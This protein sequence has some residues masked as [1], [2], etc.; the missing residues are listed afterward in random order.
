M[1]C[2]INI[3]AYTI[4]E[5]NNY[6]LSIDKNVY[7]PILRE[8]KNG[9]FDIENECVYIFNLPIGYIYPR[10]YNCYFDADSSTFY[11][12]YLVKL[13]I[14]WN[15]TEF[16]WVKLKDNINNKLLKSIHYFE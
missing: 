4:Y 13:P 1:K 14:L 2:Y 7:S 10:I 12:N 3:I 16:F 15:S 11:V 5:D 6:I 9:E 8:V